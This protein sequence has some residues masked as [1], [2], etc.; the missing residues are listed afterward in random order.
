MK[1]I[2]FLILINLIL[3]ISAKPNNLDNKLSKLNNSEVNQDTKG[4]LKQVNLNNQKNSTTVCE[5]ANEQNK[6]TVQQFE[7]SNLNENNLPHSR[8]EDEQQQL[9]V[10]ELK[11]NKT[12]LSEQQF[13]N[14]QTNTLFV[15]P[16][17]PATIKWTKLNQLFSKQQTKCIPK[18]MPNSTFKLRYN[19]YSVRYYCNDNYL[20]KGQTRLYCFQ[21]SWT[22]EAPICE[23]KSF[24]LIIISNNDNLNNNFDKSVF[25]VCVL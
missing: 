20:P 12:K 3:I 23:R 19:G 13:R 24:N 5:T 25:F 21:G 16:F 11:K 6:T 18:E 10:F 7:R 4:Q 8:S 9:I 2:N 14:Q 17:T 15:V 22:S 1:L